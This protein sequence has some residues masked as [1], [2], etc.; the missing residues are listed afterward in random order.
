MQILNFG[1]LNIDHVYAVEHFVRAGE[2]IDTDSYRVFAGGKG[3]NQSIALARA[4]ARVAHAGRVGEDGRWLID[5]LAG[6]GVDVSGVAVSETPTGHA[7]IQVS[8]EGEN[9]ILI[10][11]GA[12]RAIDEAQIRATLDRLQPGWLLLLQ[13]EINGLE[14]IMRMGG[15]KGIHIVFNPSPVTDSLLDLP[16]GQVGTFVLNQ[17]EGQ[18]LSGHSQPQRI[19]DRLRK[20]YPQAAIVLTL[21]ER[22]VEYQDSQQRVSVASE[23]VE[24]VDTTGAGDTFAGYFLAQRLGGAEVEDAIRLACRAAAL[25]VQRPGAAASI[26]HRQEIA[27]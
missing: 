7:I 5:D 2:T 6:A 4:G 26:P 24:A 15:E 16:L 11:G 23:R 25:C 19:L 17:G 13:N 14:Q 1:S 12:N 18:M 21:G 20:R 27:E 22:G 10:H 3:F 8:R 9:S